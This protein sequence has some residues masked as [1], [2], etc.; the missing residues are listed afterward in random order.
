MVEDRSHCLWHDSG[1]SRGSPN[2]PRF[3][4]NPACVS[5][6]MVDAS[7]EPT[8]KHKT[9]FEVSPSSA[10]SSCRFVPSLFL[11]KRAATS[12][13]LM[14]KSRSLSGQEGDK[15]KKKRRGKGGEC[16]RRW[17]AKAHKAHNSGERTGSSSW[18]L[19]RWQASGPCLPRRTLPYDN[20]L[21]SRSARE[22]TH[23]RCRRAHAVIRPTIRSA[24]RAAT[25]GE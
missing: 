18:R 8:K 20:F 19:S 21:F 1:S 23:G 14:G 6:S 16:T 15:A 10:C 12:S 9:P 11:L 4:W 24:I 5:C 22:A 17:P 13:S 25:C 2:H 3:Q 7:H